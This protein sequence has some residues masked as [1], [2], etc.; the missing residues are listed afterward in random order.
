MEGADES[1]ELWLHPLFLG[2]VKTVKMT[3]N[4]KGFHLGVANF[5][6]A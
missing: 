2:T 6:I 3:A 5:G 4:M 1:T